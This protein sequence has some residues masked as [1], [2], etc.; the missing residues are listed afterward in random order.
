MISLSIKAVE[1]KTGKRIRHNAVSIGFDTAPGLTGICILKSTTDTI[2][3]EHLECLKTS[4]KDDHFRRADHYTN[5]LEKFKQDLEK[6]PDFKMMVIERCY[7]GRNAEAL[8][9]LAHFG[10]LTYH[11]LK[12]YFNEFFYYGATTARSIIGFKQKRQEKITTLKGKIITRGKN[13]GKRK[14][15]TCKE[16]VHDYLKTDFGIKIKQPDEAD[17]FVLAL[18]GLL[19]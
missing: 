19:S 2:T 6:Y 10:I 3:I 7:Y 4:H 14:K 8:I 5:A 17:A 12:K 15:I 16:L 11:V 9:Q 18:A 13:K 1:E